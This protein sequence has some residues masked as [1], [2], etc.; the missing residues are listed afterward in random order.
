MREKETKFGLRVDKE[1][2]AKFRY[3]SGYHGRSATKQ[4]VQ[5]MLRFVAAYE[6]EHGAIELEDTDENGG[7]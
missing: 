4:L 5:L 3:V 7:G 1:L 2:L 6:K